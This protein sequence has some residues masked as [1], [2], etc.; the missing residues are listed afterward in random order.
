MTL[1]LEHQRP[2][3]TFG[4]D[5]IG[6]YEHDL[7]EYATGKI[8]ELGKI[9]IYGKA[10]Q[11]SSVI[12]FL[13]DNIHQLDAGMII[14]KMGVAVRTGTHCAQPLMQRYGI[15]GNIRASIAFYNTREE[16]DRLCIALQKVREMFG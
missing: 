16:I 13:M 3:A 5:N 12:S 4:L 7:L 2:I 6:K 11:K 1:A 9:K 14:D 15:E 10:K 8:S